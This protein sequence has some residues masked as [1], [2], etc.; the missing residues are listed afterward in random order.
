MNSLFKTGMLASFV[1]IAGCNQAITHDDHDKASTDYSLVTPTRVNDK[2]LPIWLIPNMPES[3]EA[4][5]GPD[6]YHIIAQTQDPDAVRP[7]SSR[8]AGGA[9]TWITTDDGK[10]KW[11]VNDSG[12]D[13]CSYIMPDGKQVVF[14]STKDRPDLPVGKLVL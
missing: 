11:R 2:E 5:Y 12:Q 14:T 3:A 7:S 9:L 13:A 6:S 8:A 1:V 10:N 4:Y